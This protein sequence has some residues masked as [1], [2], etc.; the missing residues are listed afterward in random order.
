MSSRL[1]RRLASSA[2]LI[3]LAGALGAC[4]STARKGESVGDIRSN[5]TPGLATESDRWTDVHNTVA[6]TTN[7]DWRKFN[8]DWGRFWMLDRPSRLSPAISR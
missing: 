1:S 7:D 4:S 8:S 2:C 5:L 6:V 3:A